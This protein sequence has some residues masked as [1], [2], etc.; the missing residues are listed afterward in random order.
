M[1][2]KLYVNFGEESFTLILQDRGNEIDVDETLQVDYNNIVGDIITFPVIF[3]RVH[4]MKIEAE[5]YF[6]KVELSYNILEASKRESYRKSLR[7]IEK[8]P[9]SEKV[10]APTETQVKD[11]VLM[12]E[13]V[14]ESFK[15]LLETR[16]NRDIMDALYMSAKSKDGKL[17]TVS[18]KISPDEFSKD[19]LEDSINGVLIKKN[20][21]NF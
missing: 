4:L 21:K 2:E 7:R 17:N 15:N 11:A 1:N 18:M 19:L 8:G 6:R 10:V 14:K 9:R 3:N 16:K 13:E 20:K 12:D 5:D